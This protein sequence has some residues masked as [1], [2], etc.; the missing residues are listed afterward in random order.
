MMEDMRE[1]ARI[2]QQELQ[3]MPPEQRPGPKHGGQCIHC[4]TLI[5][6]NST[7]QWHRAVRSACPSCGRAW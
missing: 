1:M 3:G 7:K 4:R 6:A 5:T 2:E